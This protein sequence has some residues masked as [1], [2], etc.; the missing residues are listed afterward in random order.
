[1]PSF[2]LFTTAIMAITSTSVLAVDNARV[3][4]YDGQDVTNM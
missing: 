2:K 4:Y 1:M 3:T